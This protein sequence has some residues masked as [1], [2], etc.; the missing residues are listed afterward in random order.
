[1]MMH[2]NMRE[3]SSQMLVA[4]QTDDV[5]S[6][7]KAFQIIK[8]VPLIED[9]CRVVIKQH[10]MKCMVYMI[11][12]FPSTK[13]HFALAAITEMSWYAISELLDYYLYTDEEYMS[14]IQCAWSHYD[15]KKANDILRYIHLR[16]FGPP[17]RTVP[18]LFYNGHLVSYSMELEERKERCYGALAHFM[19]NTI[20]EKD[21]NKMICKMVIETHT[22]ECWTLMREKKGHFIDVALGRYAFLYQ[23]TGI[24]KSFFKT[25][26]TLFTTIILF[27]PKFI[28]RFFSSTRDGLSEDDTTIVM[29]HFLLFVVCGS[30]FTIWA[31]AYES[32]L[33]LLIN[34]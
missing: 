8:Y 29:I 16:K 24:F 4:F 18:H 20:L 11:E 10:A 26:W 14:M 2:T 32:Y 31:V 3:F 25:L 28:W 15:V 33:L 23:R 12:E 19:C 22:E 17:I 21:I 6:L 34:H 5:A 1:M 7:R 27:Y 9:T 13:I 30:I